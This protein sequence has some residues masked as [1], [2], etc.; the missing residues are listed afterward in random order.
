[1]TARHKQASGSAL[2]VAPPATANG[3]ENGTDR[4]AP[5]AW[6]DWFRHAGP[7]QRA[8]A[9]GLAQQQGFLYAH[10]LPAV[11]NG[12][13]PAQPAAESVASTLLARILA[14]KLETLTP[15]EHLTFS[16]FD[17]DLDD[18]QQQAVQR[19]LA[20]PDA[21]VLQGLP[22]TG[23][24]RVL[25]EIVRQAAGRGWRVLFLAGHTASLDVVLER[26]V[27]KPDVLALRFLDQTE[28]PETLPAWLR[29]FTLDEQ[30]RAFCERVQ[31]GARGNREQVE[32]A[33][34]RH[35]EQDPLWSELNA[36]AERC[37]ALQERRQRLL[38]QLSQVA[39]AVERDAESAGDSPRLAQLA[40]L[41]HTHDQADGELARTLQAQH[42]AFAQCD[43]EIARLA[44]RIAEL[45]PGYAA[46][47][48]SRFWTPA[49]WL[50]LFNGSI[51]PEM[52]ATQQRHDEAQKRQ[53]ALA[54]EIAQ[55]EHRRTQQ[56]DQFNQERAALV[57]AESAAR[58]DALRC[59]LEALDA[60]Q[61]RLDDEWTA[62]CG[63]LDAGSI[64]KT[65]EAIAAA[66]Q[67]W[68]RRKA[69]GEEECQF[70][71][72][73]VKFIEESAPQ[74]ATRL[75]SFA[76]LLA[77][78]M[79]RWN[80]DARF[81][82]A[83]AAPFDLVIIEDAD[84]LT[85]ADLLKLSRQAARCVLVGAAVM[86]APPAAEK[87]TRPAT[88]CWQKLWHALG[89]DAGCWPHAWQREEGRL[90]CQL[91]PLT[92]EDRQH[93]E[94][95]GLAD[96]PD[97]ELGILH[98]PSTRPCLAQVTFGPNCAF[99]DAFAFMVREVQEFP[100]QP[101]GRTGWWREDDQRVCRQLG[102]AN[103]R[104][105]AWI[106][107]EAGLRLSATLDECGDATRIASIEFDKA[108]GW[109]RAK[110]DAWLA[111]HRPIRDHERTVYLQVPYRF[112]HPLARMVA[113][114]VRSGEWLPAHVPTDAS[115]A[116][117][118]E[119]IAVPTVE[120]RAW[121]KEGAGLE[122]DLSAPRSADKLPTGLRHGLPT[123]GFVNYLEAQALIRRL[124]AWS[125]QEATNNCRAA[126]LALYEGQAVLL[127]RLVEQSEILRAR[128]HPLEIALPSRLH[129]RECDIV[130]LSL[131]RSHSHRASAYGD[132]VRELPL[133]LTR[134]RTRLIVFGDPGAVCKRLACPGP[135][136]HHD[137]HDAQ[138]EHAHL[139]RLLACLQLHTP[140]LANGK[141]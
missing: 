46:K 22:G 25:V 98:R 68:Q 1:M 72:Q 99:A 100:L 32:A 20:T 6:E 69:L 130:F 115:G 113:T 111:R 33:C 5:F 132:D 66:H 118:L 13:T 123:R 59:E 71:H 76:N 47:K 114:V 121:P 42:A 16:C 48:N 14:G 19:A 81:R 136:D 105:H 8:F 27:G 79:G 92:A 73:W 103:R 3:V 93:L 35:G 125:Q 34:R 64:D 82:D 54:Q 135:L 21:F 61:R 29:G 140:A 97:I 18:V 74:W 11:A 50:N 17:A 58:Q 95:E 101:L 43:Q 49:F 112:Q 120:K 67:A 131:T 51:I 85:E 10:Q 102:P 104:A 52:D 117:A 28:K 83:T 139:A 78:T 26:L 134:A 94:N 90:V 110:A 31:A 41:R 15:L 128:R 9:L 7:Q 129:Q 12:K 23:K 106:D 4:S 56:R 77:G 109:D 138:H 141:E 57:A 70:A 65:P 30:K 87:A 24:S 96:A 45:E 119:F 62:R 89:G 39:A 137:A 2:A 122:L 84:A 86:T 124:E 75:A 91:M 40:D 63:R 55:I 126:V 60:D 36:C 127:R 53:Q 107:I 133:A 108:A 88:G 80:G 116:R 38:D 44:A 37:R